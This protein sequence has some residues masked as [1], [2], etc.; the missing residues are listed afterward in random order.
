MKRYLMLLTLSVLMSAPLLAHGSLAFKTEEL[1]KYASVLRLDSLDTLKTGYSDVKKDNRQLVVRKAEGGM[2]EHI[3]LFLFSKEA[4][5]EANNA[6]LD[7]LERGLLCNTYKLTDNKLKYMDVKFVKGSWSQMLVTAPMVSWQ[8]S[9]IN[10]RVYQV[11]MK[12]KGKEEIEILVPVKY[13]FLTNTSRKELEHNFVR[14]LKAFK[15]DK[16]NSEMDLDVAD[17]RVVK[18]LADTLY[19][20]PG[21]H[22]LLETITNATYWQQKDSVS[23]KPV[24]DVKYPVQTVANRMLVDDESIPET[25]LSIT[26]IG[27]DKRNEHVDVPVRQFMAFVKSQ[28]CVP[29]FSFE[30]IKDGKLNGALFLYNKELG[31][32]HVFSLTCDIKNVASSGFSLDSCAYL[33]TPTTNVKNLYSD[34]KSGR[35]GK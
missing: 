20:L 11:T 33:Y 31:Y 28:G 1:K 7:F 16:R 5:T 4:R 19:M 9:M 29:Y 35:Q 10:N 3:G 27:N 21:K 2:V 30:Q 18:D 17:L 23:Y 25:N 8:V 32:D 12:G 6:V 15:Y 26:V 34:M 22:Y 24:V 13:D 14:D